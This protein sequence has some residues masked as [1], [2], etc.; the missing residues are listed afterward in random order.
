MEET[1]ITRALEAMLFVSQQPQSA[2][3]LADAAGVETKRAKKALDDLRSFL[4][5]EDRGFLLREIAGGWQFFTNPECAEQVERLAKPQRDTRLSEA[6]LDTLTII[7]YRQP[8]IRADVEAIRGVA[9]GPILRALI[10]RDLVR[11]VGRADVIGRPYL[12]GTTRSFLK[13]FGLNSI[14]DLPKVEDL[15][16]R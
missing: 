9:A 1:E 6:A 7:A 11:I 13:R 2:K 10:E 5:G 14:E 8:I 15:D 3:R 12:Y 16:K 4:A